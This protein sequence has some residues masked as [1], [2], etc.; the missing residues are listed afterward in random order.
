MDRKLKLYLDTSVISHLVQEDVPREDGR[1][2][3]IM[4]NVSARNI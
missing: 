4:G 2:E 3:K 1:Y